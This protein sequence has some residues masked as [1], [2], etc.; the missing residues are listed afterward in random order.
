MTSRLCYILRFCAYA[1]SSALQQ[2]GSTFQKTVAQHRE[3]FLD[4]LTL[5]AA[6]RAD[7]DVTAVKPMHDLQ[8]LSR[9]IV[10]GDAKGKLYFFTPQGH[11]L[12]EYHTGRPVFDA[13][14]KPWGL[15]DHSFK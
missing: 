6:V 3:S 4:H 1:G 9:F 15:Y 11:L 14:L 2:Y 10:V 12:A 7:A 5:L 13:W 8:G